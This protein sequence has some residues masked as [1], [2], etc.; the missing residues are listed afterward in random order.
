M[1][2]WKNLYIWC[3]TQRIDKRNDDLCK[4]RI[5]KLNKI[6]DW[7]WYDLLVP[8]KIISFE[9]GYNEVKNW[10]D[11][12]NSLP[13][14]KS[15]DSTEKILGNWCLSKRFNKKNNKLPKFQIEQLE[16]LAGWFWDLNDLWDN[17]YNA[18]KE[19]VK[20]NNT[21][22]SVYFKNNKISGKW[23]V[24]QRNKY[25]NGKLSEYRIKLLESIDGWYWGDKLIN[26]WK[27]KYNELKIWINSNNKIP[28]KISK[29]LIERRIGKWCCRQRENYNKNKLSK[30]KINQLNKI[31]YWYWSNNNNTINRRKYSGSK[32]S[33]KKNLKK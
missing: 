23:L 26:D 6:K 11:K 14:C 31:K 22:P 25:K 7:Y 3:N 32:T 24:M 16:E 29:N 27:N 12:H 9:I 5:E 2:H 17:K 4:N 10:I 33:S 28:S 8:K 13:S 18:L 21:L 30:Y 1:I 15:Q 19:W 20:E